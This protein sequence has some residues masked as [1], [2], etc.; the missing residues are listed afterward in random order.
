MWISRVLR[1]HA[2]R[3]PLHLHSVANGEITFVS[4]CAKNAD[5]GDIAT[6]SSTFRYGLVTKGCAV[7][8]RMIVAGT[9]L[10]FT[11]R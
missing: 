2:D 6:G 9:L 7:E 10:T 8:L 5:A 11:R 4:A 1:H 3:V